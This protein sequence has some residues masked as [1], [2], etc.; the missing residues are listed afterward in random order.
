MAGNKTPEGQWHGKVEHRNA[1]GNLSK[2]TSW[3]NGEQHGESTHY[4]ENGGKA[5]T[6]THKNGQLHG[7]QIEYNENG[8]PKSEK[9]FVHG[10]Q[11]GDAV[12]YHDNGPIKS[13]SQWDKDKEV[14]RINFDEEGRVKNKTG[15]LED[16][17][18]TDAPE[19]SPH[20]ISGDRENLPAL[21]SP[22]QKQ[23][24]TALHQQHTFGDQS[25][26]SSVE[27][28]SDL[29]RPSD[30]VKQ[31]IAKKG[32]V[33]VST[34][35]EGNK[36]R[37]HLD[38]DGKPK[39]TE[40]E[41]DGRVT[42]RTIHNPDGSSHS[43]Q[44]DKNGK[45]Y[46]LA[47]HRADGSRS[48]VHNWDEN[49]NI[50]RSEFYG[51]DGPRGT[52]A[53]I[54]ETQY[55]GGKPVAD[56]HLK[57]NKP[58]GIY[59]YGDD[60]VGVP[61]DGGPTEPTFEDIEGR[62]TR[63][64][65]E[66]EA[67][68]EGL[69]SSDPRE[70]LAARYNQYHR[71]GIITLTPDIDEE[72]IAH[73]RDNK[74]DYHYIKDGDD[75]TVFGIRDPETG[76]WEGTPKGQTPPK[77]IELP[78]DSPI[79]EKE[80]RALPDD[81]KPL[82]ANLP[83]IDAPPKKLAQ[84]LEEFFNNLS[85]LDF[86]QEVAIG[87]ALGAL[88]ASTDP[89]TSVRLA[90][91]GLLGAIGGMAS[92]HLA[93]NRRLKQLKRGKQ[94]HVAGQV[95]PQSWLGKRTLRNTQNALDS[96]KDLKH[97]N[98]E[99][100]LGDRT[101]WTPERHKKFQKQ[102]DKLINTYDMDAASPL[103]KQALY[104][105]ALN[106]VLIHQRDMGAAEAGIYRPPTT[107]TE[108]HVGYAYQMYNLLGHMGGL[109][110]KTINKYKKESL[111]WSAETLREV[112][113]IM[114]AGGNLT[115]QDM[116]DSDKLGPQNQKDFAS[117]VETAYQVGRELH[118]SES[119]VRKE[120]NKLIDNKEHRAKPRAGY[121][122]RTEFDVPNPYEGEGV[123]EESLQAF[124]NMLDEEGEEA[125]QP[126]PA[127]TENVIS[128][129]EAGA[130][131]EEAV[132]PEA[133]APPEG[134]EPEAAAPPEEGVEP[135]AA[136]PPEEGVEPEAAAP[137]EE[138]VEPEAA[139]APPEEGVEPE[140][141]VAIGDTIE[142]AGDVAKQNQEIEEARESRQ[143][144]LPKEIHTYDTH[145]THKEW[146]ASPD[147]RVYHWYGGEGINDIADLISASSPSTRKKLRAATLIIHENPKEGEPK[148]S[149]VMEDGK[150]TTATLGK[151][152]L[153]EHVSKGTSFLRKLDPQ[154]KKLVSDGGPHQAKFE[155]LFGQPLE[156]FA[157]RF[158]SDS[159]F[160]NQAYRS[161]LL[162]AGLRDLKDYLEENT[163]WERPEKPGKRA[164]KQ[165]PNVA[166]QD[167]IKE[168]SN[169]V[170]SDEGV[171]PSELQDAQDTI[172]D[173]TGIVHGEPLKIKEGTP[174]DVGSGDN[175]Y[176]LQLEKED[177]DK[178]PDE[179]KEMVQ[180]A[181]SQHGSKIDSV[182]HVGDGLFFVEFKPNTP[183]AEVEEIADEEMLD[184]VL[185]MAARGEEPPVKAEPAYSFQL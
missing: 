22:L 116:G 159:H 129:D 123:P 102:I 44:F 107:P 125:Q 20:D 59:E 53:K 119:Q 28:P 18:I 175:V 164:K 30:K 72:Y 8:E 108:D 82:A 109:P 15:T 105:A 40:V 71:D 83:P 95:N 58:V 80:F 55:D 46:Q 77:E 11:I 153:V 66:R 176:H 124:L 52:L 132:E 75:Y 162:D 111:D 167:H 156:E 157:E 147:K 145:P 163:T 90:Y 93:R 86:S 57:N 181:L 98:M 65:E 130:P 33:K 152:G 34:D 61:K 60:H 81:L 182:T 91:D 24:N 42:G 104:Q 146:D 173:A 76:K 45:P 64:D 114:F 70:A 51:P 67:Q 154:A 48:A 122:G 179:Q 54:G 135:E 151:L 21:L 35:D 139:A 115:A 10:E 39:V 74:D 36:T 62:A 23:Q 171:T 6:Q 184:K 4:R 169:A 97:P 100:V 14:G 140:A 117:V 138:G 69:N 13:K 141:D 131:P 43:F 118:K 178:S 26:Y 106:K 170:T 47:H 7:K 174:K 150:F 136:V 25:S 177:A 31:E 144:D 96:V 137:P 87:N 149:L 101:H 3:L 17:D 180:A 50:T 103:E 37:V 110:E 84:A 120:F 158:A 38:E 113:R 73:I 1:A 165:K 41:T 56:Y 49:G 185:P 88:L 172:S 126:A 89:A 94:P 2:E 5:L 134:V 79:P 183:P 161:G 168:V 12:E 133:A 160:R 142:A 155:E 29:L 32:E 16:A 128:A 99:D 78:E 85:S 92:G 19:H 121:A 112:R 27:D 63:L 127:D 143:K 68:G 148:F 9:H 166:A